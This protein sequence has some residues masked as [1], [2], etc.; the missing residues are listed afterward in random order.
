MN[1]A[2]YL[3]VDLPQSDELQ[4]IR[5]AFDPLAGMVPPH[6]TVVFPFESD[7]ETEQLVAAIDETVE[8]LEFT[9]VELSLEAAVF[10]KDFCM[11][12]IRQGRDAITDLH[13][14]L[15]S[16]LLEPFLSDEYEYI[17]HLTVGRVEQES[18]R[19]EIKELTDRINLDQ[20]GAVRS[21][22]LERLDTEYTSTTLYER[23]LRPDGEDV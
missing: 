11:F 3:T 4:N 21:I 20:T 10:A 12:P 15:Y 18:D 5:E 13:D 23:T 6:I 19:D 8:E 7:I 17:P 22:I 16:D 2:I 1:R 14:R 9:Y